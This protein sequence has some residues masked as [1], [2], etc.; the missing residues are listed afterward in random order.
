MTRNLEVGRPP[1]ASY[2]TQ[3]CKPRN[4]ASSL[5]YSPGWSVKCI[6]S[7]RFK[8]MTQGQGAF[9]AFEIQI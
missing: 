6:A 1:M 9:V 4:F 5:V 7:F 8:A 2:A 3:K